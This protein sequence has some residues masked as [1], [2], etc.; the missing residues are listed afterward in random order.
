MTSEGGESIPVFES[1]RV[2][3]GALQRDNKVRV[4]VQALTRARVVGGLTVEQVAAAAG[5]GSQ[6]VTNFENVGRQP[7]DQHADVSLSTLLL[8]ADTVD[9]YLSVGVNDTKVSDY[10]GFLPTMQYPD[11]AL[12]AEM[13][14]SLG[15]FGIAGRGPF[16]LSARKHGSDQ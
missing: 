14:K 12:L 2:R 4:L 6:T 7:R 5:T 8:Y 1:E 16:A 15:D 11:A 10:W 13:R 3:R 9:A